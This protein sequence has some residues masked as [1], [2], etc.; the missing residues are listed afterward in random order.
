MNNPP[1]TNGQQRRKLHDQAVHWLLRQDAEDFS[2]QERKQ[3]QCWLNADAKHRQ[4]FQEMAALWG[5]LDH[6]AQYQDNRQQSS[7]DQRSKKNPALKRPL[8]QPLA[9]AALIVLCVLGYPVLALRLQADYMTGTGQRQNITLADG[10]RVSLNTDSALSVHYT[11]ARREVELLQ[12]EAFFQVQPDKT[13]PFSVLAGDTQAT[14]LGTAYVVSHFQQ[15]GSVV[16]T[17]GRVEVAP[18]KPQNQA[19][20]QGVALTAGQAVD[21]SASSLPEAIHRIDPNNATAWLR[22]KIIFDGESL[23]Q[24]V[25]RLNRYHTGIIVLAGN[26]LKQRRV[27]GVFATKDPVH[28]V[29]SIASTLGLRIT[30]IGD[31]LIVLHS[32]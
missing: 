10:T 23:Q 17:E 20:A 5:Q 31:Y 28:I 12:G 14:A 30:R 25:E 21:F 18:R 2:E 6:V 32:A 19:A 13:R 8:Y 22:G 24:V 15:Q 4:A 29:Q 1:E 7:R 16:V 3:L 27:T 9:A 26:D 11:P